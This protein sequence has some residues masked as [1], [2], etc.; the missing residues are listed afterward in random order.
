MDAAKDPSRDHDEPRGQ[1]FWPVTVSAP[2][3]HYNDDAIVSA[4]V[5]P[6]SVIFVAYNKTH[7]KR[8]LNPQKLQHGL[9]LYE[10]RPL[11]E[12][13]TFSSK[14]T[15]SIYE[16]L[17]EKFGDE[18][19]SLHLLVPGSGPVAEHIQLTA[20]KIQL[21]EISRKLPVIPLNVAIWKIPAADTVA[22]PGPRMILV[23]AFGSG[24]VYLDGFLLPIHRQ[25][26]TFVG[27]GNEEPRPPQLEA[28]TI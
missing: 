9:G 19:V 11:Y 5:H 2:D 27:D 7:K 21:F 23:Q 12:G 28:Q 16:L 25:D 14:R 3:I 6:D 24:P 20:M 10:Q 22:P 4:I 8:I 13:G 18:P 17:L 1:T 26:V 15:S